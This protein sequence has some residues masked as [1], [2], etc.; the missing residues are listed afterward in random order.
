VRGGRRHRPHRH[1]QFR[2]LPHGRARLAGRAAR[3]RQRQRDRRRHGARGAAGGAAARRC[4]PG[5]TAPTRSC[6][7]TAS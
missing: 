4:W 3:L 5:S 1:L 2:P 7:S 6:C